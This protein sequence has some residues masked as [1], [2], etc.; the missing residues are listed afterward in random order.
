[1]ALLRQSNVRWLRERNVWVGE[2]FDPGIRERMELLRAAGFEIV[3]FAGT[4]SNVTAQLEGNQLPEDLLAVYESGFRQ[5]REY[6]GLVSAWEMS[7][8]PDV[9]YC[10]DLPDRLAAYNKAMY[11]GLHAG[12]ASVQPGLSGKVKFKDENRSGASELNL[13]LPSSTHN[14]R[15]PIVLM[16]ALASSP[17]PWLERAANNGLFDYTDAL[18]FHYYGSAERLPAVIRAHREA[19]LELGA[20]SLELRAKGSDWVGRKRGLELKASSSQLLAQRQPALPLWLTECGLDTVVPGDFLNTERR[21]MQADFILATA[22][23][24][25]AVR[26]LA[27][28]MPFILVHKDDPFSMTLPAPP[29]ALPAWDAYAKLTR[30][31]AWPR[32]VLSVPA[33]ERANPV[34]VQW[35]PAEGTETHK[36]AGT[37]RLRTCDVM[38]GEFRI[39]NFGE[40]TAEGV[41]SAEADGLSRKMELKERREGRGASG[42]AGALRFLTPAGRVD[43]VPVSIPAG[44]CVTVP[45]LYTP[46]NDIGYFREWIRM[47]FRDASGRVS[48]V[49][50]GVE[51]RP[52]SL[53]FTGE[54]VAVYPLRGDSRARFF[55]TNV[56]GEPREPWRLFNGLEAKS[57]EPTANRSERAGVTRLSVP[58]PVNDPL[59]PPYALAA[60]RG[61]PEGV[62]FLRVKMDRPMT[63]N[64]ALRVDLVDVDGERFTIWENLGNAYGVSSRET[65]LALADFH[66]YFWSK[67]VAGNRRL[68]PDKVREIVLRVYLPHGGAM[69]VELEWMRA[70]SAQ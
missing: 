8:E 66:P 24:A 3:A 50:F 43:A 69:D 16:G 59:A 65:W 67:A 47:G 64:A 29:T 44:G 34:V 31:T 61:V 70:R 15:P 19:M 60:L 9:G 33:G 48:P 58:K 14:G 30:E 46:A 53:D 52:E 20:M 42:P 62:E 35:M 41:L 38:A 26:D 7:G 1:M 32:R 11:L 18:N 25:L 63:R 45:A 12:A 13:Q 54:P 55:L 6:A 23:H 2:G 57:P 10:R 22:R 37:Y 28:F 49:A 40:R 21:T 17:G 36:V 56:E 39:Y 27:M 51:R 68:R 4:P 5:G